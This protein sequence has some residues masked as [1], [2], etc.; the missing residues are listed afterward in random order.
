MEPLKIFSAVL[1]LAAAAASAQEVRSEKYP[2]TDGTPARQ[3]PRQA[4]ES[5][6][7]EIT[8][9]AAMIS[10]ANISHLLANSAV[11]SN[12]KIK[13]NIRRLSAGFTAVA[14]GKKKDGLELSYSFDDYAYRTHTAFSYREHSLTASFTP[15]LGA[16]LKLDL[17][18]G[19]GLVTDK[20][21]TIARDRMA[22]AG[23][24]WHGQGGLTLK[25]GYERRHGSV[26]VNSLKDADGDVFYFSARQRLLKKHL[27]FLSLRRQDHKA[28][29]GNYTYASDSAV[30]GVSSQWSKKFRLLAAATRT[31]KDYDNV[32]TRFLKRRSD[33][34]TSA[35]LKPTLELARGVY[36]SG[37]FT[38]L[39]NRSNVG[40]KSYSD[41]IYSLGVEV[42]F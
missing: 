6:S 25:A 24:S 32:D 15:G 28:S 31:L 4:P 41:R 16:G 40:I 18:L 30:L 5:K 8:A 22:G 20:T 35:M 9:G 14:L 33:T 7:W 38:Y 2:Q 27:A 1:L 12:T 34:A 29:G 10:D 23:L 42:K 17:D 21:G 3:A 19:L 36:A 37:S 26:K 13:D 11:K 39:D